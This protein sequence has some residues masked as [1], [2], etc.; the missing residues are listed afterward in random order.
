MPL[1]TLDIA[2]PYRHPSSVLQ[3][4]LYN[5]HKFADVDII[6]LF[7]LVALL[8]RKLKTNKPRAQSRVQKMNQVTRHIRVY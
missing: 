6:K 5:P 7:T 3:I 8:N 2:S 4:S 1:V